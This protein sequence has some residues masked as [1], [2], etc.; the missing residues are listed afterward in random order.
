MNYYN[1]IDKK[2]SLKYNE[3]TNLPNKFQFKNA[4]NNFLFDLQNQKRIFFKSKLN[5]FGN[6]YNLH[7]LNLTINIGEYFEKYI[8]R[9][10]EDLQFEYILDYIGIYENSTK[11]YMDTLIN[12][13]NNFKKEVLNEFKT[14]MNKFVTN[15]KKGISNF[16]DNDY[17]NE[18]KKNYTSCLGYSIDLL[19]QTIEEDKINYEKYLIYMN[20]TENNDSTSLTD[21]S[22]DEIKFN[23]PFADNT[24]IGDEFS[25]FNKTE[26]LFFCHRNNYFNY[27]IKIFE[28]FENIYRNKL[29]HFINEILNIIEKSDFS[30]NFLY[31]F[32][33]K[34]YK[35]NPYDL[36][37]DDIPG[38]FEGYEDMI[39][40]SNYSYNSV[41]I[42]YLNDL[43]IFKFHLY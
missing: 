39:I 18:V 8:E 29:D 21:I 19:N 26:H 23:N 37:Q 1:L 38:D 27:T 25:F 15:F 43:L 6:K 35:L 41:Y 33:R 28:N 32:L 31:N 3:I 22:S 30:T 34:E 12:Y 9:S 2:F 7:S 16:V 13:F 10:Y 20:S 4:L 11:I 5:E 24:D 36:S 17:I 40:F 14:L 42:D